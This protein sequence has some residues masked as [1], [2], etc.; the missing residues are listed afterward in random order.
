MKKHANET[1]RTGKKYDEK[2]DFLDKQQQSKE[3]DLEG[4]ANNKGQCEDHK[5]RMVERVALQVKRRLQVY[6]PMNE[7]ARST[8]C[9]KSF[10]QANESE[11]KKELETV[12]DDV[13]NPPPNGSP[14]LRAVTT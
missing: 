11:I 3:K 6:E 5:N 2:I 4:I 8:P 7:A 14:D 12:F 13:R 1:R 10:W 9:P